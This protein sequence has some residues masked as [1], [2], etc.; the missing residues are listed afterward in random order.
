MSAKKNRKSFT[1]LML[2]NAFVVLDAI[3]DIDLV[4]LRGHALVEAFLWQLLAERL[5]VDEKELPELTFERLARL[6]AAGERYDL[7]R[8]HIL[9]LNTIR[10]GIAHQ[11]DPSA[12]RGR[13]Q[14][15]TSKAADELR[16]SF[17]QN[18]RT[19]VTITHRGVEDWP[20]DKVAQT[21]LVRLAIVGLILT[22]RMV[23]IASDPP[24]YER[25]K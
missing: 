16:A 3:G 20:D 1:D 15:F 14:E 11:F 2:T 22:L 7:V 4:V 9:F 13:L 24:K 21:E 25:K 19:E 6:A 18:G 10:N 8:E 17:A 23:S 12:H 5:A